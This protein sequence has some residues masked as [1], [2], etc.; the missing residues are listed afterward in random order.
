MLVILSQEVKSSFHELD[1]TNDCENLKSN[2]SKLFKKS[3]DKLE[4]SSDDIALK[5]DAFLQGVDFGEI[6]RA[7][8]GDWSINNNDSGIF[9]NCLVSC[10]EIRINNGECE[11]RNTYR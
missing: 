1:K 9:K 6:K 2:I 10:D 7:L 8:H 11:C 4:I 5:Y 3:I